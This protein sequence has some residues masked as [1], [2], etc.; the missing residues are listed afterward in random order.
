MSAIPLLR[1]KGKGFK[2]PRDGS[3][4]IL[5]LQ[6]LLE[7]VKFQCGISET[8]RSLR[9]TSDYW[10]DSVQTPDFITTESQGLEVAYLMHQQHSG[11]TVAKNNQVASL[12][13]AICL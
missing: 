10:S 4:L 12:L 1:Q 7:S 3:D 11:K 8:K 9:V 13:L 2:G 5:I 6:E